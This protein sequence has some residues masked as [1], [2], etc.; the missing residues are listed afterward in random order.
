[1]VSGTI[2]VT[3]KGSLSHQGITLSMEGNVQLQLSAKSVGLFEAFYN[4]IKPVDLLS[5]N[6][7]VAKP[8]KLPNGTTELPFEIKLEPFNGQQLFETYHGVF[9]NVQYV[10]KCEMKRGMLAK[11]SQT[12]L[13][14]IV[15][16]P[17]I[18]SLCV[19]VCACAC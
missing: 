13:E 10:L 1:M 7:E 11:D 2:A 9:V 5:Y 17:V 8:G 12:Q 18:S 19:R 16:V 15:E 4:S 3:S 6:V 14:F